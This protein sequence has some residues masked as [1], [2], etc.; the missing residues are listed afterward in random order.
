MERTIKPLAL[1]I[2]RFKREFKRLSK[3]SVFQRAMDHAIDIKADRWLSYTPLSKE[4]LFDTVDHRD[5][6]TII[7]PF[8]GRLSHARS[9]Y[10]GASWYGQKT[11]LSRPT[12]TLGILHALGMFVLDSD[13]VVIRQEPNRQTRYCVICKAHHE[14]TDFI[15]NK[16]YLNELS[17]ACKR[18]LEDGKRGIWR[19][20]A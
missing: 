13:F 6:M 11:V 10:R 7:V 15:R 2:T 1:D 5:F 8:G 19:K 9:T 18:S 4:Q 12:H 3:M 14:V 16:R 17:F 20:V